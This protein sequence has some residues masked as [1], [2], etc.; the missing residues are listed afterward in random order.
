VAR[1]YLEKLVFAP[2]E[3]DV[4]V[5]EHRYDAV[6]PEDG[7]RVRYTSTLIDYGEVGGETSIARTTGLPPAI[8][9]KLLL[10]GRLSLKGVQAPVH[11]EVCGPSLAELERLRISFREKE[12]P[13]GTN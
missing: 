13:L 1:L 6:F 3:R 10:E 12:E 8:G 9:A 7:R 2:G 4:V 5:M 11:P